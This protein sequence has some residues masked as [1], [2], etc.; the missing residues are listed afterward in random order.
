MVATLHRGAA[1][2]SA[3]VGA[4]VIAQELSFIQHSFTIAPAVSA[5]S[6]LRRL[7]LFLLKEDVSAW[8]EALREGVTPNFLK[9]KRA[10]GVDGV[11]MVKPS[12]RKTPWWTGYLA[13]YV[14]RSQSLASLINS[15]TGA[16]LLFEADGRRFAAAFGYGRHMLDP[17]RYVHDFGLRVVLNV[18]EPARL[19]SVD[20]KTIDDLTVHTRRD[21]SRGS[22]I[23][24]FGLD[25]SRDLV[26]A[27]TG[28]PRD[29]AIA[30]RVTGS[31]VL[32]L[33]TRA[34]LPEL[35]ALVAR[36]LSAYVADDYK[37]HFPWI[38][39]LRAVR[40]PTLIERLDEE[41]IND[42][43]ARDLDDMH[44]AAPEVLDWERLP[45][46]SFSAKGED[47]TLETDPKVSVYRDRFNDASK[48]TRKRLST[49]RI[50]AFSGE[51]EAPVGSWPVYRCLVYETRHEDALYV[52]STGQWYSVDREFAEAVAR[53]IAGLPQLDLP[54]PDAPLGTEEGDYNQLAATAT[55]TLCLDRKLIR[56]DGL[57]PIELC[58]LLSRDKQFVHVKR[59]GSSSTLS[60]LFAQGTVVAQLLVGDPAFR[61]EARTV[62]DGL[63][64]SFASAIPSSRPASDECEIG[65]VVVTRSTRNSPL[66]LP[67]FSQVNLRTAARQI[68]TLGLRVAVK[69]VPER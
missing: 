7:S 47:E 13:P 36:L 37:S 31:D 25:V 12:A 39:H 67:F 66:T 64:S 17:Q 51:G 54:M 59:R 45:V 23:Q 10:D 40:D 11:V 50:Y 57:D 32:A 63:D 52:L 14:E 27:V 19:K 29:T 33:V 16:L 49:D 28:E 18:V 68:Q 21:V 34:A 26:R 3:T 48:I 6:P 24:S 58:D 9:L 35:P 2:K 5:K 20:A 46:F 62:V 41:L 69:Q 43:Q 30:E 8:E 15:S 4:S 42:L 65:Y 55:G 60:H 38:D 44:L 61:A 1:A 22:P 56:V 53:E